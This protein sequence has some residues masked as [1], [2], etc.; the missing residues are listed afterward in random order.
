MEL[1]LFLSNSRSFAF[2]FNIGIPKAGWDAKKSI[3][4]EKKRK[5]ETN[6]RI[7]WTAAKT[8]IVNSGT[9]KLTFVFFI[10]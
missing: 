3:E 4:K 5:I 7:T 9:I 2:S 8:E 10:S 1:F 6:K